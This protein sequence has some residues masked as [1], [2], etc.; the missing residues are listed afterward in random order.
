[1]NRRWQWAQK[2]ELKWWKQY[3]RRQEPAEYL[4]R[5]AM[6]WRR[7][8]ESA[9]FAPQPGERVLDAG[10]G[11]A[12]IFIILQD[13]EVDAVDP[14]LDAYEAELTVFYKKNYP[15]V[16]FFA[17]ALE[18]FRPPVAYPTVYC[19]NAVNHVRDIEKS[20]D[21]LAQAVAPGGTL[22]LSVDAHRFRFLKHL[23]RLLPGDILHP[24]QFDDAE[25]RAMMEQRGFVIR[26]KIILKQE[27][28]FRHY[29][30]TAQKTTGG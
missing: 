19:L 1:M 16:R 11:P 21:V 10:C 26:R 28:L 2:A 13:Q 15:H 4:H 24:Q 7:V 25:Y 5:K 29:L 9:G 17:E 27:L 6:Y 23:F 22:L 20:F 18:A 3:L 14:L 30:Y 8:L 12:G